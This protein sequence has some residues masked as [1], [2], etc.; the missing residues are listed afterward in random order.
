MDEILLRNIQ[1]PYCWEKI[2]VEIDA[3]GSEGQA[4]VEDCHICCQP[5]LIEVK[6]GGSG[7]IQVSAK[8]ENE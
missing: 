1:C 8:K 3:T 7:S 4:Y 2:P 5:I 6:I